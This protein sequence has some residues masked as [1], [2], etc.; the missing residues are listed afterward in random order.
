MLQLC[1]RE[2]FKSPQQV[3][4]LNK[5]FNQ[6]CTLFNFPSCQPLLFD[7]TFTECALLPITGILM[8]SSADTI[9]FF[10]IHASYALKMTWGVNLGHMN[11]NLVNKIAKNFNISTWKCGSCVNQKHVIRIAKYYIYY[12]FYVNLAYICTGFTSGSILKVKQ[13]SGKI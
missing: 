11:S 6:L 5:S 10:F 9:I 2:R 4:D 13:W 3:L 1:I 7:L 12:I 8:I